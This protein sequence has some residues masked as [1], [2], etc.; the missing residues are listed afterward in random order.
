MWV[1]AEFT[2]QKRYLSLRKEKNFLKNGEFM[3]II[4]VLEIVFW[5]MQMENFRR[6]NREK[7]TIFIEYDQI[8]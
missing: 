8:P 5:D 2:G 3:A 4:S 1:P 6:Q 7:K